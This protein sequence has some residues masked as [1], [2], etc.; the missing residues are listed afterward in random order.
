MIVFVPANFFI[1]TTKSRARR[2][3]P[4]LRARPAARMRFDAPVH[5]IVFAVGE[6]HSDHA[7]LSWQWLRTHL[8]KQKNDELVL[9]KARL[10]TARP[11]GVPASSTAKHGRQRRCACTT[12]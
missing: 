9:L 7:I 12:A 10:P 8:L 1:G 4:L 5:K 6:Q 3:F 11:H 2:Q